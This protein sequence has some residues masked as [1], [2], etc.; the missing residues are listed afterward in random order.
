MNKTIVILCALFLSIVITAP[1]QAQPLVWHQ[2]IS[3]T[4]VNLEGAPVVLGEIT[5]DA[6]EAGDVVVHFDG[7]C[8]ADFGDRVVLAASD[9]SIWEDNDGNVAVEAANADVDRGTFSH[10][11]SYP[12]TAGSHTF[13]AVGEVWVEHD[14]NGI[15]SVY[16]SLTVKFFPENTDEPFVEHVGIN[17]TDL[18]VRGN[19]VVVG[20]Q[21]IVAGSSGFVL[22][23]FDGKCRPDAGDLIILAASDTSDWE[24]NDGNVCVEAVDSDINSCSFSHSRLYPVEAGSHTFYAIAHNYVEQDGSG[25]VD[26]YGSL[27]IEFFPD[28]PNQ[29]VVELHGINETNLDVSSLVTL[30]QITLELA[31]AGKVV[32]HFDGV[33]YADV[34]DRIVLA[35]SDEPDWSSDD[36]CVS[37]EAVNA[38][39]DDHSFSHTRV[40]NVTAGTHDFYAVIQNYVEYEGDGITSIYGSLTV[41]FFPQ[42]IEDIRQLSD[43]I[44]SKLSLNQNY[45]NPFNASTVIGFGLSNTTQVNLDIFDILGNKVASLVNQE[46]PAGYYQITWQAGDVSSGLYFYRLSANGINETKRMLLIK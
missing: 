29:P 2:G 33:C 28:L 45:P 8:I 38:D 36:G 5:I 24:A 32:V 6:P 4:D 16:G 21:T 43:N 15:A 18:N 26:L 1:C 20:E 35:A 11:R 23:R 12:V 13:Y 7:Q 17:E 30:D 27:T 25:I 44:P 40:Y 37:V 31:T 9:T 34:G 10:T 46:M 14:G 41:E 19:P 39:I 42:T 3:E 22:V